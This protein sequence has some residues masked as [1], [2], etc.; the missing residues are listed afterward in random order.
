MSFE[1]SFALSP[2]C[3]SGV[4]C[5]RWGWGV[6]WS[7]LTQALRWL[8]VDVLVSVARPCHGGF[9]LSCSPVVQ[10]DEVRVGR[11]R[12]WCNTPGLWSSLPFWGL[13]FVWI[14]RFFRPFA[15]LHAPWAVRLVSFS[16]QFGSP[17]PGP[18]VDWLSARSRSRPPALGGGRCPAQ[19]QP[20]CPPSGRGTR[21]CVLVCLLF[22][23][24][25]CDCLALV[26][27]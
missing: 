24:C 22:R 10:V 25:L 9:E 19:T 8:G 17:S 18:R 4:V 12:F 6:S 20:L 1:H 21:S 2:C 23:V 15:I 26:F 3:L 7:L 11:F 14:G 13:S 27:S 16:A 5:G